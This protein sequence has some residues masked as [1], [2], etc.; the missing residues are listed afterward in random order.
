MKR[1]YSLK[2][3]LEIIRDVGGM[4]LSVLVILAIIAL[5]IMALVWDDHA[6]KSYAPTRAQLHSSPGSWVVLV[7][8][9]PPAASTAPDLKALVEAYILGVNPDRKVRDL[10]REARRLGIPICG[11]AHGYYW[12]ANDEEFRAEMNQLKGRAFDMIKTARAF[13]A[14]WREHG[15]PTQ[16]RLEL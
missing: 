2:R 8:V 13:G 5:L 10:A 6:A 1:P 7:A 12:A 3:D 4:V 16:S 15:K 11:D 9:S 14:G